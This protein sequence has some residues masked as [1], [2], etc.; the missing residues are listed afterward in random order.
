MK[1]VPWAFSIYQDHFK[2]RKIIPNFNPL[3]SSRFWKEFQHF[4]IIS[5]MLFFFLNLTYKNWLLTIS[6]ESI[7]LIWTLGILI[8]GL[9]IVI[10]LVLTNDTVIILWF[11]C[12][13]YNM[14]W[15]LSALKFNAYGLSPFRQVLNM[16]IIKIIRLFLL[17]CG[18]KYKAKNGKNRCNGIT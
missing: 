6:W 9:M 1:Y 11:R 7:F 13:A 16:K 10:G 5:F 14:I 17:V 12:Q 4:V 3:N 8:W 2:D 18:E 15:F